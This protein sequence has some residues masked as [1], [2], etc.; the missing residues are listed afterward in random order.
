MKDRFFHMAKGSAE[1]W[2]QVREQNTRGRDCRLFGL[3]YKWFL[4]NLKIFSGKTFIRDKI[5]IT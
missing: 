4:I 5:I 3:I 1:G 2:L